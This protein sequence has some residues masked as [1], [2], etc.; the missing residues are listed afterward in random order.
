MKYDYKNKNEILKEK[1]VKSLQTVKNIVKKWFEP[2]FIIIDI[3][4]EN[5]GLS[6]YKFHLVAN[7]CGMLINNN[8]NMKIIVK[9]N[10]DYVENEIKK[11]NLLF[12]KRGIF[13]VRKG[14]NIIF[15]LAMNENL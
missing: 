9:D 7:E 6:V 5:I 12:E 11:N 13:E 4:Y 3:F 1:I 8:F 14:E 10:G 15:Y 2:Y